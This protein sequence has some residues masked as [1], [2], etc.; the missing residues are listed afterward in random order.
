MVQ[1]TELLFDRLTRGCKASKYA[2]I[3]HLYKF[4]LVRLVASDM[5]HDGIVQAIWAE[6]NEACVDEAS[7]AC[8]ELGLLFSS[9]LMAIMRVHWQQ[10]MYNRCNTCIMIVV[11]VLRS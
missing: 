4:C 6:L 10:Y 7:I 3:S 1:L 8:D 9:M 2:H 11:N 5:F